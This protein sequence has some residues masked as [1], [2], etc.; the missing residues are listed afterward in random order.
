M[1][2]TKNKIE[3]ADRIAAAINISSSFGIC[4]NADKLRAD[5]AI[6]N[7]N[8]KAIYRNFISNNTPKNID[9]SLNNKFYRKA[10][11]FDVVVPKHAYDKI[12]KFYQES[13]GINKIFI[14]KNID[15]LCLLLDKLDYYSIRYKSLWHS[16]KDMTPMAC[17][18]LISL[19]GP[20]YKRMTHFLKMLDIIDIDDT[21]I[22]GIFDKKGKGNKKGICKHYAYQDKEQNEY[23]I[24]RITN[25]SIIARQHGIKNDGVEIDG[26]KVNGNTVRDEDLN[27]W[28][29]EHFSLPQQSDKSADFDGFAYYHNK[30]EPDGRK[31]RNFT[32]GR[33]KFGNRLYHP[34]LN[35]NKKLRHYVEIDGKANATT[36]DINNSHPYFFSLLFDNKFLKS[37]SDLFTDEEYKFISSISDDPQYR[38]SI[39]IFSNIAA[40]GNYYSYMQERIDSKKD[41]KVINMYFFYGRI[42]KLNDLY[43][44]FNKNFNFINI[45][46]LKLIKLGGF[47]RLCQILQ[48]VEA[49]VMIDNVFYN[50][51]SKNI[52]IIPLHDAF[53]CMDKDSDLIKKEIH[54]VLSELGATRL[55]EFDKK[56]DRQIFDQ[57]MKELYIKHCNEFINLNILYEDLNEIIKAV[58]INNRVFKDGQTEKNIEYIDSRFMKICSEMEVPDIVVEKYY[59][60]RNNME[61]NNFNTFDFSEHFTRYNESEL[62]KRKYYGNNIVG[63]IKCNPIEFINHE[64]GSKYKT[65]LIE[66]KYIFG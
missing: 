40:S 35:M 60:L 9:G 23:T 30:V 24:H 52:S 36:V 57:T 66:N 17:T 11:H 53:M 43:K 45:V 15:H 8:Q 14:E 39:D 38:S 5:C 62:M 34:F 51:K 2:K 12:L 47:K 4:D 27:N 16:R 55:P 44:L 6:E 63:Y 29:G 48:Q 50:L 13:E 65:R 19:V 1:L 31:F 46:K 54:T 7:S 18:F 3:R 20:S 41:V 10:F 33:D 42:N 58:G 64:T 25:R 28:F 61:S 37:V 56:N 22:P 32:I 26:R 49:R 21:Y 59:E